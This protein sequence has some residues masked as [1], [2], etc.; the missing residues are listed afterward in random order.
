MRISSTQEM[1]K[2]H[3]NG[4]CAMSEEKEGKC[5]KCNGRMIKNFASISGNAKYINWVCEGCSHKETKCLG[6]LR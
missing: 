2:Y 6:V 5:P 3:R 1:L 4:K